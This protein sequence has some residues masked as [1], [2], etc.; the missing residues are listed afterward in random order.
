VIEKKHNHGI[1]YIAASKDGKLIASGDAYRYIYV[2]DTDSKAEVGCY[3]YHTAK[4]LHL[5]FNHDGTLLLT[6]SNDSNVGTITL[7]SKTKKIIQ[8]NLI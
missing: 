4:T 1:S 8:S 3:A 5:D 2:F 7:A 6:T